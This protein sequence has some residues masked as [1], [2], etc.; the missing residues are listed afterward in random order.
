MFGSAVVASFFKYLADDL[1]KGF[2][3]QE[4]INKSRFFDFDPV[5]LFPQLR[6][7]GESL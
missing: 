5:N 2:W 1:I 6:I 3:G 4:K 7:E